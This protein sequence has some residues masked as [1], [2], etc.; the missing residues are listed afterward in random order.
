MT[1]RVRFAIFAATLFL[2]RGAIAQLPPPPPPSPNAPLPPPPPPSRGTTQPEPRD[3]EPPSRREP[4]DTRDATPPH[5]V[6]PAPPPPPPAPVERDRDDGIRPARTFDIVAAL[7]T[8]YSAALGSIADG[9]KMSTTFSGQIP[10]TGEVGIRVTPNVVVGLIVGAGFG[11]AA[12]SFKNTCDAIHVSCSATSLHLGIE[13]QYH[14]QPSDRLNPWV[15]YGFALESNDVGG[16]V[17]GKYNG[18]GFSGLEFAR[19]TAGVDYRVSRL[20]A[21]GPFLDFSLGQY[22]S[23]HVTTA[24]VV[25]DEDV[26][27]TALH[28]WL[29]LGLR[30]VFLP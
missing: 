8:G 6:R 2:S 24:G 22:T 15:G 26:T 29:T 5:T 17:G 28:S 13:G 23:G 7:R 3:R 16:K 20:V 9:T 4:R 19:L 30:V 27:P 14:F 18:V 10:V 12:G 11:G 1:S 21:F 25:A